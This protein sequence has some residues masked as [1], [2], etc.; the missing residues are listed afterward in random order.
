MEN[1]QN[2]VSQV[3]ELLGDE[4]SAAEYL[5]KCIYSIGLGSNDYLN[6]YFMPQFYSTGNQYTPQQYSE[7]LIQQYAEQLR[8]TPTLSLS[9]SV[10]LNMSTDCT[11]FSLS[12]IVVNNMIR[13]IVVL[14]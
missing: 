12:F 4:D 5:S 11:F 6:N 1:Y 3:V 13:P 8:V 10:G 9:R 7:N 2:T 14:D